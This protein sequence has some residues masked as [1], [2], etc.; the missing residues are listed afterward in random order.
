MLAELLS[1]IF[2]RRCVACARPGERL[3]PACAAALSPPGPSLCQRCGRP[4]PLP[5][6]DCPE[7]RGRRLYFATARAAFCYQGP[8]KALVRA[9]KYS[10]Q[11]RLAALMAELSVTDPGLTLLA[12]GATLTC[13]PLHR[14]KQSGRGYNQAELYAR[15]LARRLDLPFERLLRKSR[16]TLSQNRLDLRERRRNLSSSF[17]PRTGARAAGRVVLVDDVY[18]TGSTAS[19]C[20]RVI[21]RESGAAVSVW[22]FART[23]RDGSL[24]ADAKRVFF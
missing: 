4:A 2:P 22:S 17:A 13:V 23:V 16:P 6:P 5:L 1:V 11:W 7:C 20:A 8:A 9:L 10:G 14:S 18:T 15:A 19:E 24:A 3:C 12:K 21:R